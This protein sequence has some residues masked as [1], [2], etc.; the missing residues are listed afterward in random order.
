MKDIV[1]YVPYF[2]WGSNLNAGYKA[3]VDTESTFK[4]LGFKELEI[5][6]RNSGEKRT[7][8]LSKLVRMILFKAPSI[9]TSPTIFFQSGT[10]IDI[11][12]S[13]A[14]R[15]KFS[16]ARRVIIIHDIESIRY[17]R[18]IDRIREKIVF[19]RFTD[20]VC[21]TERLAEYLKNELGF[22]GRI[23]IS[24]LW[25]YL[26]KNRK[27]LEEKLQKLFKFKP[28]KYVVSFAGNLSKS[29]FLKRIIKELNPS[30]YMYCLYGKGY[31]GDAKDGVL[32]YKGV[33]HPDELPYK[34]EGHFGL[35]W[36][37]EEVNGISGTVGH[38]LKYNSPHKASLYIVS[39]LPLIVW[40]ESAIYETVKEY[41]IGF[42]VNSLK[43]ID[44]ILSKVSEK[45]YQVW[46]ENTIKLGKKLASGEN[47][48][49]IINRILSK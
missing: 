31:G 23:Y 3:R 38:Y 44:E 18:K 29:T 12:I 41:N 46:R 33:F 43:E 17:S 10:G 11:F 40:K 47:V 36:D 5:F 28:E 42:G 19:E 4:E 1:Y 25:D 9:Q 48:K 35:V 2:H 39:G 16:R 20:A 8:S 30:N 14:L 49:E 6:G 32:E 21:N 45:D 26:V 24:G 22:Q 37:G 15:R 7:L 34:I 13:D 27:L